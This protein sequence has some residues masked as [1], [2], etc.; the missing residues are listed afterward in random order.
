MINQT[1]QP[2]NAS[3]D[4]GNSACSGFERDQSKTFTARWHQH[5]ISSAIKSRQQVVRLW[6]KEMHSPF[7]VVLC[8]DALHT[9]QFSCTICTAC[10][11][12]YNKL[13][14][15]AT[16][17]RKCLH[18]NIKTLQWLN[19]TNKQQD[20]PTAKS[21]SMSRTASI[22]RRKEC[23]LYTWCNNFNSSW[24]TAI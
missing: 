14:I 20:W 16:E 24:R 2:T 3:S 12:N 5:N 17:L 10:T 9:I 15:I 19:A 18:C 7:Q 8:D 13:C 11:T 21:E 1:E 4:N 6:I 23:A 22:S